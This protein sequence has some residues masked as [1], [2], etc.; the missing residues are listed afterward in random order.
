MAYDLI[1]RVAALAAINSIRG[2]SID[3]FTNLPTR[4]FEQTV[5]AVATGG[6][7]VTGIGAA[8]YVSDTLAN[9]ALAAAHPNACKKSLDGRYW[10]LLQTDGEINV[11]Q[12][13][14]LGNPAGNGAV[15]DQVGIQAALNYAAAI[16]IRVVR[17]PQ[18]RY[19]VWTTTRTTPFWNWGTDGCGI[20][21]PAALANSEITLAGGGKWS[22]ISFYN[23]DGSAF[24]SNWQVIASDGNPWRGHGLYVD[25]PLTDPGVENRNAITL[26]RI[27][28]D[29]G[30]LANGNTNWT[31][32][33]TDV[34]TGWDVSHKGV[35]FRPDYFLGDLILR[36][37]R[38]TGFRGELVFSSNA[39]ESRLILDGRVELGETNGQAIN[40]AGGGVEC[41]GF[42]KAWNCN[43]AFEGWMGIGNLRGEFHNILRGSAIQGGV[44]DTT[45]TGLGYFKPQRV[46][47]TQFAGKLSLFQLDVLITSPQQTMQFG[48]FMRG[49]IVAVDTTIAIG[50]NEL[51]GPFKDGVFDQDLEILTIVDKANL[52]TA[53]SLVGGSTAGLK[54]IRDCRYQVNIKRSRDAILAGYKLTDAVSYAGS[55]GE[56]VVIERS[57]GPSQRGSAVGGAA[58]ALPDLYPCFRANTFD[59]PVD[60]S[61]TLQNIVTTPAIIPRGDFMYVLNPTANSVV[62]ATLP[63]TGIADGHELTLW[64]STGPTGNQYVA[65]DRSGGG[66][67]LPAR[68]LIGGD[69]G[70][71]LRFDGVASLWREVT[72]PKPISLSLAATLPALAANAISA[73][74]TVTVYGAEIGML[75]SIQALSPNTALEIINPQV[76]SANT[77]S[78]RVRELAG[79][80]YA[81]G[82]YSINLTLEHKRTWLS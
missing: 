65:L 28:L 21:I 68:R 77:V 73:V 40:P 50:A 27:W 31:N 55:I 9:A 6:H 29:G 23:K 38:V 67:R 72:P 58:A 1:A 12:T 18:R 17:F 53:L 63:V 15:N 19:A 7:T 66:A 3:L 39:R 81:G 49:K 59:R 48:S 37:C 82:A 4:S 52:Q 33:P 30:T 64:N 41:T 34:P 51:I 45:G 16:G 75:A 56:N 76:T 74:Q 78:F 69:D 25:S 61:T 70:I 80:A 5:T 54:Q 44:I 79:A 22:R 43:V 60:S 47:E 24:Q 10:R 36:N 62:T 20:Y 14:A 42:V 26:D 46:T 2:S 57:G 8:T 35:C 32:P 13:G 11:D 71:R